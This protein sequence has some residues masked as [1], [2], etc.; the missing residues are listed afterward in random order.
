MEK[1]FKKRF[2]DPMQKEKITTTLSM[3]G[4][5]RTQD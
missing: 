3:L 2:L 1:C 5:R 4:I